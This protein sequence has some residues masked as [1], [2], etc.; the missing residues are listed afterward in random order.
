[1]RR[2]PLF[3]RI[4]AGRVIDVVIWRAYLVD[5]SHLVDISQWNHFMAMIVATPCR[6]YIVYHSGLFAQG[7][8]S[9]LEQDNSVQIV[10][11]ERNVAK[12]LTAVRSLH[13]DVILVEEPTEHW[14]KWPFLQLAAAGRIVT[15]SLDHAYATVYDQHRIAAT[16]PADLVK[17]IRGAASTHPLP[18][19]ERQD[20]AAP[21]KR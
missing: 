1:M 9:V 13:P 18:R 6:T 14:G 2:S 15:L 4:R 7:V 12:A 20:G 19:P 5:I 16:D 8:R 21:E 10:G 3:P 17:A 11:M